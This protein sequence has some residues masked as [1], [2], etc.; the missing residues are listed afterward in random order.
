MIRLDVPPANDNGIAPA[1]REVKA[2]SPAREA[3]APS[4]RAEETPVVSVPGDRA[5]H[6]YACAGNLILPLRFARRF[7]G[8]ALQG[9]T[10]VTH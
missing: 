5:E 8:W 7:P 10:S 2:P 6:T 9:G 3:K 4:P 1:A